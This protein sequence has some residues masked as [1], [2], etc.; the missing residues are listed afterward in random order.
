LAE[1]HDD[2]EIVCPMHLNPNVQKTVRGCLEGIEAGVAKL[3]GTDPESIVGEASRLLEHPDEYA[4][5]ASMENPYGD[6]RAAERIVQI[7]AEG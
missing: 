4:R 2:V 3:V 5:M 6:G 1:R 7:L